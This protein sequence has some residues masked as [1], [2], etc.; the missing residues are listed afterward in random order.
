[1]QRAL[2]KPGPET[3]SQKGSDL[4]LMLNNW[5]VDVRVEKV[6]HSVPGFI[7]VHGALVKEGKPM[8]TD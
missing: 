3:C 8:E 2:P 4:L 5:R 6:Q 7:V 1:M